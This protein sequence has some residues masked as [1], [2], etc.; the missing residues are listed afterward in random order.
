[1]V[2]IVQDMHADM[3]QISVSVQQVCDAGRV[4]QSN[5]SAEGRDILEQ[6]IK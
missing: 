6:Q 1:L 4:V 5:T 3:E 2:C